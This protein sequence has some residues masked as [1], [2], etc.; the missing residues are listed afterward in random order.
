ML[1]F[2]LRAA[3]AR[4]RRRI[5]AIARARAVAAYISGLGEEPDDDAGRSAPLG[6]LQ[7]GKSGRSGAGIGWGFEGSV[8]AA[9][10]P[11]ELK[12]LEG[13]LEGFRRL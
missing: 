6:W 11:D 10:G 12:T 5:A 1:R 7:P 3:A 2:S 9:R 13:L 4:R 8:G